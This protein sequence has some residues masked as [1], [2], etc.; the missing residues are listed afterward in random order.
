[1]WI[2]VAAAVLILLILG[3]RMMHSESAAN[4]NGAPK[5]ISTLGGT[6]ASSNAPA[7]TAKPSA[8]TFAAG[9]SAAINPAPVNPASGA[10]ASAPAGRTQWRVVAYTFNHQDQAQQKADSITKRH[11]SLNA[12]VFS[13]SGRAPYLVTVGGAMNREEA[14]AFKQK[15][16]SQ[17]LPHDIYAQNYSR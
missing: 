4:A 16:R 2:A 13:P 7:A 3:W 11:P 14:E 15:A 1:M 12:E 8:N 5:P 9:R 10:A 6:D 17:G